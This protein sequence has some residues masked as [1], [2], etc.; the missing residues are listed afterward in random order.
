M[1]WRDR[2]G[3]KNP[4][5]SPFI[6]ARKAE[7]RYASMLRKIARHVGDIVSA[8]RRDD[9]GYA[10]KI[11]GALD[12]YAGTIGEW[13]EA[14]ASRMVEEVAARDR[15]AW[16]EAS[17]RLGKSLRE[18]IESAPTGKVMRERLQEQVRLI[19]SI[20]TD[21]AGRVRHLATEAI[22]NGSRADEIAKE[23]MRSGDV[24]AS[25]ANMIARTEVSRTATDLTQARA[26]HI[27]S[28]GYFWRTAGDGDVRDS[29][30]KMAGRFVAW[31]SPPTLDG[32]TGHA[33][34][35]PNCRCYPDP[36]V[37]EG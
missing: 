1:L 19:R 35:F 5:R 2:P 3:E 30:R 10:E 9:P 12:R 32:M 8:F 21:A 14:A 7:A 22:V 28:P 17:R 13:A 34:Q 15:A 29:H 23:I 6:R 20:P 25:R 24:A 31:D 26:E 11:A 36:V 18:E 16:M 33:G 4:S 37:P 27:R